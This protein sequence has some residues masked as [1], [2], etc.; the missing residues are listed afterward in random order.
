MNYSQRKLKIV[1][2]MGG[3]EG[4]SFV[5]VNSSYNHRKMKNHSPSPSMYLEF[6]GYPFQSNL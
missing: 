1:A 2:K 5:H 6:G 3:L 4:R